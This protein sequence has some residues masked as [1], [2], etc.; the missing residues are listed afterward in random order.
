MSSSH[1]TDEPVIIV[2]LYKRNVEY[3]LALLAPLASHDEE[4]AD[5]YQLIHDVTNSG[6]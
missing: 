1:T 3:L 4:A 6:E 2:G 5:L